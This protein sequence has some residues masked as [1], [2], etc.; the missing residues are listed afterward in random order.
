MD[1][2]IERFV[3]LGTFEIVSGEMY[4]TDPLFELDTECVSALKNVRSGRW[5]AAVYMVKTGGNGERVSRLAVW[6]EDAPEPDQLRKAEADF[7]VPVD[8]GQA[9]FFDTAHYRDSSVIDTAP[10]EMYSDGECVWFDRCCEIALGPGQAGFCRSARFPRRDTETTFIPAS[11]MRTRPARSCGRSWRSLR[12]RIL[13]TTIESGPIAKA[14][15]G[16]LI[17]RDAE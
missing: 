13:P 12:K 2:F 4:V 15:L 1:E 10:A 3:G 17:G 14:P 7:E 5:N 16:I 11:I 9:G 8:A 6:H